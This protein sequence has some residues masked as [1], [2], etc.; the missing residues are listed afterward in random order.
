MTNK[1]KTYDVMREHEGDRFYKTGDTRDLTPTD[2]VVLLGLGVLAEH[3]PERFKS[4]GVQE[5][6]ISKELAGIDARLDERRLE[7]NQLIIAE[8]KRLDDARSQSATAIAALEDD[9]NKARTNAENEITRIDGEVSAARDNAA[10]EIAKIGAD[11]AG[12]KAD[13]DF[14]NKADKTV[15]NKAE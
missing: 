4:E 11:L 5:S 10:A 7:V 15:K 9:L 6:D 2:A 8:D 1:A 12:K 3:D 13:A 14:A